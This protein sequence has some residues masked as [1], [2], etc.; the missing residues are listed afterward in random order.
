[1]LIDAAVSLRTLSGSV[2]VRLRRQIAATVQAFTILDIAALEG[3]VAAIPSRALSHVCA[4]SL[5]HVNLTW[6]SCSSTS[7]PENLLAL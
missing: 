1:M 2:C 6:H 5:S 7:S 4:F 3:T